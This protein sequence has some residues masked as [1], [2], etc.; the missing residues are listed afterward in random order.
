MRAVFLSLFLEI[1][2]F[3]FR[4]GGILRELFRRDFGLRLLGVFDGRGDF[5]R[6]SSRVGVVEKKAER[7]D[8]EASPSRSR[9][10]LRK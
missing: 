4:R 8:E 7:V 2:A 9:L 3:S 5:N 10:V 1:A 6:R